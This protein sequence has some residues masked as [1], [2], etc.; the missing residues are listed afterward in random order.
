MAKKFGVAMHFDPFELP[1]V[2]IS[3]I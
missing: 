1:T 2:K 3:K